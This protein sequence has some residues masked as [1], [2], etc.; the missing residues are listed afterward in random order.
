LFVYVFYFPVCIV[1]F[2]VCIVPVLCFLFLPLFVD[3]CST[4]TSFISFLFFFPFF[5]AALVLCFST[6]VFSLYSRGQ[7]VTSDPALLSS[8]AFIGWDKES[9]KRWLER[10]GQRLGWCGAGVC[11]F[12]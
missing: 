2:V 9:T 7:S 8:G 6:A 4:T 1:V 10:R 3:F 5:L 11:S 12:S